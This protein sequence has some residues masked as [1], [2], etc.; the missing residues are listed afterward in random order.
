M[1]PHI[2]QIHRSCG[3]GNNKCVLMIEHTDKTLT[4]FFRITCKTC[5]VFI[6]RLRSLHVSADGAPVRE[7]GREGGTDIV[8][9]ME[10]RVRG[11]GG[12]GGEELTWSLPIE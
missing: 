12:V 6:A 8:M 4:H 2:R 3:Q 5:A 10:G 7:G 11:E 9:V 1:F